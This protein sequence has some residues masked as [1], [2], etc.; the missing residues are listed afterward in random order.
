MDWLQK[1]RA[2]IRAIGAYLAAAK[3]HSG[4][5]WALGFW[6]VSCKEGSQAPRIGLVRSIQSWLLAETLQKSWIPRAPWFLLL[7]SMTLTASPG[8]AVKELESRK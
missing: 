8:L 6:G 4:L 7:P 1:I 2:P 3:A 5:S